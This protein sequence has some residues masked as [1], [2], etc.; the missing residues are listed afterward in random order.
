[1]KKILPFCLL[2]IVLAK[3]YAQPDFGPPTPTPTSQQLQWHELD[4]YLFVHFGPNTFTDEEWGKGTEHEEVFDPTQLDCRQW[5]RTAKAAGAKGIIITAKHHD[6]FCLWPSKY[7]THTVRESKWKNGKGDVLRE[8]SDAC[9]EY[10]LKFGV[11]LSPWDR[12][13]PAYGTPAYNDVY[14]NMMKEIVANYGPIFEMWW[15]GANGEGP[16]G[17]KQVYDW[18]RFQRTMRDVSPNTV[19]FS[20][21]GPD[22]RWVGNEKGIAGKTNWNLLDTAGFTRGIGAPS[23][24]SLNEGNDTAQNWIPAECDVS[25]RPG[26]FYHANEDNKVKSGEDLF[27]LYLKSV[28]RGANLLL[29]VPADRRGLIYS[30]DSTALVDFKNLREQNF[31]NDLLKKGVLENKRLSQPYDLTDQK[32]SLYAIFKKPTKINCVVLREEIAKGQ[33]VKKMNIVLSSNGEALRTISITTIG[34][35]R[36][37]TFPTVEA[38]ELSAVVIDAKGKPRLKDVEAYLID[39]KLIEKE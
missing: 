34:K 18:K 29:N 20:D 4:Y 38:T 25:I 14:V 39:E 6:G 11:Y 22:I 30:K 37:I 8:L 32:W 13:H 27:Q 24:K 28:G 15:D 16:N 23:A 3:S 31:K 26:W 9:K 36:I 7:S 21:I 1:M 35:K 12:N 5:C 33:Q 2:F 19:I 17:K 10:G